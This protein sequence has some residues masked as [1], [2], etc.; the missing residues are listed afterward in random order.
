MS[1]SLSDISTLLQSR[2]QA[3][4]GDEAV[5]QLQHALQ[6]AALAEQAGERPETIVAA[7]LHDLG[8]LIVA[9]RDRVDE[10]D[11]SR[12]ELHQFVVLPFLRATFPESVL[13]P[14]RLHVDAKRYLCATEAAYEEGLSPASKASLALQGG[15]FS[16]EEATRFMAQPHAAEAIRLRRYDDLAKETD[17]R[18]PDLAHFERYMAQV[19]LGTIDSPQR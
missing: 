19:A 8:H 9:E 2:G 16:A 5:S 14:I 3:Q 17:W 4:Y 1:L 15:P 10:P 6:S 7:L 12:D 13:A 11:N 18:G